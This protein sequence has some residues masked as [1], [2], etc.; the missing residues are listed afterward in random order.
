MGERRSEYRR[1]PASVTSDS[2]IINATTHAD[3]VLARRNTLHIHMAPRRQLEHQQSPRSALKL[4]SSRAQSVLSNGIWRGTEDERC[5]LV[6]IISHMSFSTSQSWR[7]SI[8]IPQR[9]ASID[10]TA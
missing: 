6:Y 1:S 9:Q 10:I 5:L 8:R 3:D 7:Q 2:D 4:M